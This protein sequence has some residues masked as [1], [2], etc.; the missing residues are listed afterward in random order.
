MRVIFGL[1][2]L[3]ATP[4]MAAEQSGL[5]EFCA[6][7]PGLNTPACTVDK[8]HLQVELGLG[9]WTLDKQPD[10]RTDSWSFG[11]VALRY[12]IGDTTELRLGWT[13]YGHVR[14]KDRATGAIDRTGG[15]GDVTIGVKQNLLHPDGNGFAVALLPYA[16]LPSGHHDIGAGDWGAGLLVPISYDLSDTFTLEATPEVDAAVDED[17]HG[18][19]L[20]FGSAAGIQA[21]L[22]KQA[23][24]SLE[25]EAIRDRDPGEHSTQALAGLSFAYQPGDNLQLDVGAT[26]GLNRNTPDMEVSFGISERF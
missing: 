26:A 4:A 1:A 19:H 11:D 14:E 16:T 24:V 20:A 8:G 5:R 15:I 12:G 9:D 3:A 23:S 7:R 2:L 25:V 10:T 17:G 6:D 22:S 13:A 21:K 18:R